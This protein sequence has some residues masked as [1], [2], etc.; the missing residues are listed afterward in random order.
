MTS[1][2]DR[3]DACK[4]QGIRKN[5]D[6]APVRRAD[7]RV[8][9]RLFAVVA[10]ILL[11]GAATDNTADLD[12]S[13]GSGTIVIESGNGACYRF[14]VYLALTS[15]QHRRGLMFVRQLPRYTGMLFVYPDAARRSMWMK[16]TYIPL[17]ILFIRADGTVSSIAA[18]TE[19]LSLQSIASEESVHFVLELNAGVSE[20]LGI[21][22]ES[23]IYLPERAD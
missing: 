4:L 9:R 7:C 17:D 19:P 10:A 22:R 2:Y 14:D 20:A 15:A 3:P 5:R 8:P 12:Q 23:R 6:R 18:E 1:L 11:T 13:F 21:D 16:N